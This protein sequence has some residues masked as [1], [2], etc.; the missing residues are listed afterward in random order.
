MIS[1]LSSIS[2]CFTSFLFDLMFLLTVFISEKNFLKIIFIVSPHP[3]PDSSSSSLPPRDTQIK[4]DI[5]PSVF[6]LDTFLLLGGLLLVTSGHILLILAAPNSSLYLHFI[7]AIN[8]IRGYPMK[9]RIWLMAPV[10]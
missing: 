7:F 8:P 3:P 9:L 5:I 4:S 2:S 6:L 10:F 1:L